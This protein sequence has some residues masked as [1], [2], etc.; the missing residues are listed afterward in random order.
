MKFYNFRFI[1]GYRVTHHLLDDRTYLWNRIHGLQIGD[2][3][4]GAIKGR[5]A[6]PESTDS[7]GGKS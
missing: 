1:R 6:P 2:W 4:F 5:I 7:T 3:F